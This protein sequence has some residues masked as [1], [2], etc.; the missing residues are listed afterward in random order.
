[1]DGGRKSVT[2][3]NVKDTVDQQTGSNIPPGKEHD[4]CRRSLSMT[5][6]MWAAHHKDHSECVKEL[7]EAGAGAD[8]N[9]MDQLGLTALMFAV[10]QG[11][12]RVTNL[13]IKAGADV[14]I[15][16]KAGET[17]LNLTA[18]QGS[19]E[20]FKLLLDVGADVNIND[21]RGNSPLLTSVNSDHKTIA[22]ALLKAGADVNH[23]NED[24]ETALMRA[25]QYGKNI[26]HLLLAAGADVNIKAQNNN[27]ALHFACFRVLNCDNIKILL[28][29]GAD[30]NS[31]NA[32]G[33]TPLF[34]A[35]QGKYDSRF[36]KEHNSYV[37]AVNI[38]VKAG[39]DVNAQTKDGETALMSA[40]EDG[41][42][43]C[44]KALLKA[45]AD[46]NRGKN[47]RGET[48][49]MCTVRSLH[50]GFVDCYTFN[51]NHDTCFKLLLEAEADVITTG[52]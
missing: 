8:V 33:N 22:E 43:K 42:V 12:L 20:C 31:K 24:G 39:A 38:L 50:Q 46:V 40:A 6:L 5:P 52:Q 35:L 15:Q 36:Y 13:L 7:I 41:F 45:G 4:R 27:H 19:E 47:E 29:A 49:L 23:C 28:D 48:A 10:R 21:N 37:E 9:A 14:N 17:A 16:N 18:S 34:C 26:I 11:R 2:N 32:Y 25:A 1:M 30:V 3:S 44:V 51:P